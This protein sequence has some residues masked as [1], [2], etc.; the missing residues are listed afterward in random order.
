MNPCVQLSHVTF[1][2]PGCT[3]PALED[4]SLAISPGDFIGISGASGAGKTTLAHALS[5]ALSHHIDGNL[6]GSIAWDGTDG[7]TTTLEHVSRRVGSVLQDTDA[8]L[9]T[10]T[11]EDEIA[12]GLENFGVAH[13]LIEHR[14]DRALVA[15]GI[16]DLRERELDTLSGGQRQRVAIASMLALETRLL[17]LDEATSALDPQGARQLY[18]TVATLCSEQKVAAVALS[19]HASELAKFC[20]DSYHLAHG[21]L[22]KGVPRVED[23]PS[24]VR[25][26]RTCADPVLKLEGATYLYPTGDGVRKITAQIEAGRIYAVTG[27]NGS[28]K[29]TLLSLMCGSHEPQR[30][31]VERR[32]SSIGVLLQNPSYQMC[33]RSALEQVEQGL[34]LHGMN[35][36]DA[37]TAARNALEDLGV[38]VTRSPFECCAAT[39]QLIGLAEIVALAPSCAILDEPTSQ[40]D[41]SQR[42]NVARRLADLADRGSAVVLVSHDNALIDSLADVELLMVHGALKAVRPVQGVR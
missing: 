26:A 8:Q 17:V 12:F 5:G 20:T 37:Q 36:S 6:Q 38:P 16:S 39:R 22:M 40:L 28:G 30:G 31:R 33:R 7:D 9:L 15:L 23:P 1:S 19:S 29:S 41:C 10:A 13:E 2:Y 18:Q 11:A 34:R 4:V 32:G 25:T 27:P 42:N 24:L 35:R 21:R 14:V 3:G